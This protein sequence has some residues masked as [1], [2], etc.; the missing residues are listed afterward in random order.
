MPN[1]FLEDPVKWA[2]E[3]LHHL[4]TLI[5]ED[6]AKTHRDVQEMGDQAWAKRD[7][8]TFELYARKAWA[9][10]TV[11]TTEMRREVLALGRRLTEH[12]MLDGVPITVPAHLVD[13]A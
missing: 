9:E 2:Q 12:V 3:E 6:E 5:A 13:L 4:H 10:H 11:R 7:R 1:D 8:E